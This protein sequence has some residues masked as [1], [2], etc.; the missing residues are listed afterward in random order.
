[1]IFITC[2]WSYPLSDGTS[3][4]ALA[5]LSREDQLLQANAATFVSIPVNK[6]EWI[7][8]EWYGIWSIAWW[9]I[10]VYLAWDN[11]T[12]NS[13]CWVDYV[14]LRFC[15]AL[16]SYYNTPYCLFIGLERVTWYVLV[17]LDGGRVIVHRLPCDSPTTITRRAV[18]RRLFTHLEP[19]QLC[20]CVSET[21][22]RTLRV[23]R[24]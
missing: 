1:M 6:P 3:R 21:R 5:F 4:T 17:L 10:N 9:G 16:Y 2:V 18:P 15:L 20:I 19:N 24:W 8:N 14:L 23:R 11:T 12:Y 22:V 13:T 7:T